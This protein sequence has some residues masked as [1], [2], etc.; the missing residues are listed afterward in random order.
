[1]R[2]KRIAFAGAVLLTAFAAGCG[3][4]SIETAPTEAV[5]TPTPAPAPEIT[6]EPAVT[7]APEGVLVNMEKVEE[8]EE[9]DTE[10]Y[11]GEKTDSSSS[12]LIV[13]QTGDMI[14]HIFIRAAARDDGSSDAW[15]DELIHTFDWPD[16]ES[17]IYYYENN[18]IDLEGSTATSYDIRI[19]YEEENRSELYYRN[20]PLPLMKELRLCVDISGDFGVPYARYITINGN[21]EY[22]TLQEVRAWYGLDVEETEYEESETSTTE[23][24]ETD[25]LPTPVPDDE[26]TTTTT[27]RSETAE[28]TPA[29]STAVETTVETTTE[30]AT[31]ATTETQYTEPPTEEYY[32][33]PDPDASTAQ[34]YI[35]QSLGS[36][37]GAMGSPSGSEYSDEPGAG[38]TG[39][40]Y[41]GSFT[42]STSVDDDGNE[43]IT[44][45]W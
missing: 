7:A 23:Y 24:D 17:A 35:G 12:V 31:T 21:R 44:G 40:H 6:V 16:Q 14:E 28:P 18:Q 15:G 25:I 11:I 45:I 27:E 39:Y 2:M 9:F 38:R 4:R 29:P 30:A 32:D 26:T 13:N 8:P 36:L 43:T 42:V 10:N 37:M 34:G 1:M 22:S 19:S 3:T 5:V 20:L 33:E 41:Y